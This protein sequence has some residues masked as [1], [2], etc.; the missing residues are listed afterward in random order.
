MNDSK[1]VP[2]GLLGSQRGREKGLY[3]ALTI[4]C[5]VCNA[6]GGLSVGQ[7]PGRVDSA[8]THI[9]QPGSSDNHRSLLRSAQVPNH[10]FPC[11]YVRGPK[12]P[13]ITFCCLYWSTC[14]SSLV[15]SS[16][17]F[18]LSI[19]FVCFSFPANHVTYIPADE[20]PAVDQWEAH[21]GY[22]GFQPRQILRGSRCKHHS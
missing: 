14:I 6:H 2:R 10:G 13:I 22:C 19:M 15:S 21:E 18:S 8:Q 4:Y 9:S 5:A 20:V 3:F 1:T 11:S 12:L 16:F 7:A 17:V